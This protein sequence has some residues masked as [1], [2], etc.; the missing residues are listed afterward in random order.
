MAHRIFITCQS[1][2]DPVIVGT[3][4]CEALLGRKYE[5]EKDYIRWVGKFGDERGVTRCQVLIDCNVAERKL[6]AA[7]PLKCY[8][9]TSGQSAM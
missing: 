6:S 5:Y 1:D 7:V 4:A 8:K 2:Q 3:L 9:T